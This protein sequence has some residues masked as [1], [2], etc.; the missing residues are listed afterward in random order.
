MTSKSSERRISNC[1]SKFEQLCS[2]RSAKNKDWG[3]LS[4]LWGEGIPELRCHYWERPVTSTHL[5]H[6]LW[7]WRSEKGIHMKISMA[8]TV[9][10]GVRSSSCVLL[11]GHSGLTSALDWKQK[12]IDNQCS[13]LST[14]V[15]CLFVHLVQLLSCLFMAKMSMSKVAYKTNKINNT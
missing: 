14:G 1:E 12:P 10:M 9:H 7:S 6:L 11:P 8:R 5:P 15:T 3:C 4:G 2:Y 13:C